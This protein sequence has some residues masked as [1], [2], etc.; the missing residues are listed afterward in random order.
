MRQF[1]HYK[2]SDLPIE[3]LGAAYPLVREIRKGV[4][5]DGW[6]KLAREW[7][8]DGDQPA[9]RRGI[10]KLELQGIMR[11]LFSYEICQREGRT[12]R[13]VVDHFVAMDILYGDQVAEELMGFL[14]QLALRNDCNDVDIDLGM[15]S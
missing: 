5:L 9:A 2:I 11:G 6:I 8:E 12:N 13:L 1:A 10:K 7:L 15:I 14:Y 3:Q 4:S